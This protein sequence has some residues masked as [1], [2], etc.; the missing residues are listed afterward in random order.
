MRKNLM[1]IIVVAMLTACEKAIVEDEQQ[2]PNATLQIRTTRAGGE[3]ATISYPVQVY[4]F[5]NDECV[6]V[7]TIGDEGQTLNIELME[8]TYSV[9]A[10]GGASSTD[11]NLPTK[12]DVTTTTAV[13]LKDGKAL[14]DLMAA[15]A[16]V[17]LVDGGTNTVTLSLERKVM[18]LQD[19]T[20]KQV[21]TAATASTSATRRAPISPTSAHPT[22]TRTRSSAPWP[23]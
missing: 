2:F 1:L 15:K 3:E 4:V 18:L 23:R 8:G 6:A 10:V 16:N 19:V 21:P 5:Q 14:T 20:I 7:Q 13:T 17:T 22:P 11:Y 9:Y 12:E